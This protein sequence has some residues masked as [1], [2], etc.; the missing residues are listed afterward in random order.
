[1]AGSQVPEPGQTS[2]LAGGGQMTGLVPTQTPFWQV[3]VWVQA[4]LSL[5][6]VPLATGMH[7][8]VAGVQV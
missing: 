3:S 2:G 7:V 5:H 4:L 8:P 1:V 6:G